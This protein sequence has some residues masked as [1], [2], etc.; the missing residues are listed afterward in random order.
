MPKAGL[1]LQAEVWGEGDN[2][3]PPDDPDGGSGLLL[4]VCRLTFQKVQL[5]MMLRHMHGLSQESHVCKIIIYAKHP[6]M[7]L[8]NILVYSIRLS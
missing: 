8:V 6:R 2:L 7:F 3:G 4:P 5:Q 1:S